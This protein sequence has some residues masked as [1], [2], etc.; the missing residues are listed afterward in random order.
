M[1]GRGA[2]G[3]GPVANQWLDVYLSVSHNPFLETNTEPCCASILF[4]L[5]AGHGRLYCGHLGLY[6][7]RR[8]GVLSGP[9]DQ[10]A[11][12]FQVIC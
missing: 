9:P 2:N 6:P 5:R 4:P 8:A 12:E 7:G 10:P 11:P 1:D 3:D